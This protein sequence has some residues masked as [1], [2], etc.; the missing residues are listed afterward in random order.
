MRA[1]EEQ[2]PGPVARTKQHG[3]EEK[4]T[5]IRPAGRETS[6]EWKN[7]QGKI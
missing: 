1:E 3:E 4:Y 6:V 5:V 2:I 7:T